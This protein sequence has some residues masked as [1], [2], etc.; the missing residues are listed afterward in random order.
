MRKTYR[1]RV[2]VERMEKRDT[3][4]GIHTGCRD[5]HDVDGG[6]GSRFK[7]EQ[8]VDQRDYRTK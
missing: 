3:H 8:R 1:E 4:T 2:N 7:L 6:R 5:A